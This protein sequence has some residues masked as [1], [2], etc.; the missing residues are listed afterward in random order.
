MTSPEL[1]AAA[2][3]YREARIKY[4]RLT[5][6]YCYERISTETFRSTRRAYRDATRLYKKAVD[7]ECAKKL[8]KD[9]P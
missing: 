2:E 6:E 5:I 4:R 3:V 1:L 8:I 9:I 7:D